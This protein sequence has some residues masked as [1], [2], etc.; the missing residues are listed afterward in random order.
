MSLVYAYDFGNVQ[1]CYCE[2]EIEFVDLRFHCGVG[3]TMKSFN[4]YEPMNR[5]PFFIFHPNL[6][7]YNN[8]FNVTSEETVEDICIN[9]VE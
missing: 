3:V 2:I 7:P 9:E 4:I 5:H 8:D 1:Y 6:P